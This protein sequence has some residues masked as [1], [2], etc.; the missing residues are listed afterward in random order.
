VEQ[1]WKEVADL[2]TRRRVRVQ[3]ERKVEQWAMSALMM[4]AARTSETSANF[5]QT[6]QRNNPEDRHI[7]LFELCYAISGLGS[8]CLL[9][10]VAQQ[11][12]SLMTIHSRSNK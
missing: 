10:L 1:L 7:L 2:G 11:Q 6:T 8:F 9:F 3:A 12:R 4:E 5:Y